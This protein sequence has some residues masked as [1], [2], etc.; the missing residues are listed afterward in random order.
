MD[1]EYLPLL[2]E[3]QKWINPKKNFKKDDLVLVT[4]E[5]LPRGQWP[6]GRIIET[7]PDDDTFV[8][9]VKVKTMESVKVHPIHKLV[10]LED[11]DT[12]NKPKE[13]KDSNVE[14]NI[15]ENFELENT[16]TKRPVRIKHRPKRYDDFYM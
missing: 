16:K 6:L 2:Q 5:N 13:S 12:W 11:S 4:D 1:S 14:S 7:Y 8:R 9:S 15:V 10:H 3:R